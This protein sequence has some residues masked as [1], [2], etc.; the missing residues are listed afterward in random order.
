MLGKITLLS[1]QLQFSQM[2]I[3][4]WSL[5]QSIDNFHHPKMLLPALFVISYLSIPNLW[6]PLFL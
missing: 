3:V 5:Q 2:Y 1:V 6:Q 4:M